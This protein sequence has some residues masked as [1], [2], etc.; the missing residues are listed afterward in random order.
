MNRAAIVCI[1]DE[2]TIL[3]S[4]RDQLTRIV[5]GEYTIELAESAEEAID[6]FAELTQE[7]IEVPLLICDQTMPSMD[8][9]ELLSYLHGQYPKTLKILLTGMASLKEVI[10]AVNHANLYRYITKPW[11][12]TDLGLTVREA[13]RRYA[14]E[15]QL[16]EQNQIL[17]QVNLELQQ[18]IGD[19]RQA[20]AQLAFD[21]LHDGLTGLPNRTQLM[22][23]IESALQS[24]QSDGGNPFAVLFIDLDRFK[25]VNDSLGHIVGDQFL[26]AI[27]HRLQLCLRPTDLVA[28]LGG[29]EFTVLIEPV[30]DPAEATQIAERILETL[31][32]P[33]HLQGH[34]LFSGA[35]I[36]IAFGSADYQTAVDLL[37]D[38]D[39]A[40]YQAK[41]TGRACYALFN[42][43]LHIQSLK[44]LQIESDLRQAISQQEFFLNYQPIVN[45]IT[46]RLLGF[47]A[48]V[49]WQHP[50][51]GLIPP[52]DFIPVAEETGLIIALGEWVLR[53]ACHQLHTWQQAFPD[54]AALTVSV[55]LSGQQLRDPGFIGRLDRVLVETQLDG[56]HVRLELTESM[57]IEHVEA[58]LQTLNEIR[59]RNIQ[60]SIDDFGIGYS[61]LN[62]LLRF[63]INTLKID[64]TFV[65]RM[66]VDT[67]NFEIVRA[68]AT[69]AHSIKMDVIAEGIETLQ[70]V[71]QLKGLGCE[72]GQG[73]L[74]AKPLSVQSAEQLLAADQPQF[75]I[76]FSRE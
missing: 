30:Q 17:Q 72:F 52:S 46:G 70:Q 6:L 1:D 13:L 73:Y 38:A 57:L 51:H 54:Q 41:E 69:L 43:Q 60:L 14:Q 42:Q 48:L 76:C 40:M 16:A 47:E 7:Q 5:D 59:A 67:E 18:E 45:L 53:Q 28:R 2:P 22:K 24:A 3:F 68:I 25:R 50:Q 66:T 33:F 10:Y 35:S 44:L 11:D 8:G 65:D 20:E 26:I 21:A 61:S 75:S 37:R 27:A 55:N 39:L 34:T 32:T 36:G 64:R 56:N 23:K 12:E 63:P 31:R 29:D 4:L 62:Y 9:V 71:A 58:I 74:F 15:K 19:R 49:R